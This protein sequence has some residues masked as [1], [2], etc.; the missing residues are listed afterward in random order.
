MVG[1]GGVLPLA[2]QFACEACGATFTVDDRLAGRKGRCKACGRVFAI[3]RAG[4]AAAASVMAVPVASAGR[5]AAG[6]F[7]LAPGAAGAP[8]PRVAV[9]AGRPMNWIEAVTSQVALAPVT[10]EGLRPV[11]RPM[12]PSALDDASVSGPY[13]MRSMPSLAPLPGAGG[14]PAGAATRAYRKELGRAQRLFRWL[15]ESAYLVSVPF[16]LLILIGIVFKSQPLALLGATGAVLLNIGRVG[17]GLANLVVIPFRDSPVQGVLFLIPP[18]TF[19]YLWKNW[20]RV[21]KPVLR[22]LGPIGTIGLVVLAFSFIP[23]LRPGGADPGTVE[24]R[25][26]SG[27]AELKAGIKDQIRSAKDVDVDQVRS[28]AEGALRSLEDRVGNPAAGFAPGA[29]GSAPESPSP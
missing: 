13:L 6:G 5:A 24:G 29:P 28:R 26:T 15:N 11:Q 10:A 7:R 3:P 9:P 2:I 12:L 27:A 19:Y 18:L 14:R 4:A 16:L 17:A 22:V 8:A 1:T 25:L 23:W 20:D 21:R